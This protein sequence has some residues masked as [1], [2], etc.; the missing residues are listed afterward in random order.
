MHFLLMLMHF[1]PQL[2]ANLHAWAPALSLNKLSSVLL[3]K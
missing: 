2:F 1:L 3:Y